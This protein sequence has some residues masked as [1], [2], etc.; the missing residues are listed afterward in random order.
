MR[1]RKGGR[2]RGGVRGGERGRGGESSC[3]VVGARESAVG[4]RKEVIGRMKGFVM[5]S[6]RV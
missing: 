4:V 1:E 2:E 5:G 3:G 6:W